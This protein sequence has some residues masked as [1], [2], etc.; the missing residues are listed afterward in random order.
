MEAHPLEAI[1]NNVFG[2]ETVALAAMRGGVKKLVLI[3]TDG[4]V[5]TPTKCPITPTK[6]AHKAYLERH[7]GHRL[8]NVIIIPNGLREDLLSRPLL[9][10]NGLCS[11]E[12]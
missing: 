3:S 8:D 9:E 12:R 2:T 4:S 10:V 6:C 11:W 7:A 5:S 1:E